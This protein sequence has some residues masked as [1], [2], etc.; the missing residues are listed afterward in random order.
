[1]YIGLSSLGASLLSIVNGW[2]YS[3]TCKY[4]LV[5]LFL[6]Y[7]VIYIGLGIFAVLGLIVACIYC[8]KLWNF[9]SI[10]ASLNVWAM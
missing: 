4:M 1:M 5:I 7:F 9:V 10:I 3:V 8:L 6:F 2:I